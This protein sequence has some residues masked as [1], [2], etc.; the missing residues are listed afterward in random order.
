[1]KRP[2]QKLTLFIILLAAFSSCQQK[3]DSVRAQV[4]PFATVGAGIAGLG[5]VSAT[6]AQ[7]Q[8]SMGAIYDSANAATFQNR[9][10]SL[11]TATMYPEDVGTVGASI[12]D[13]T[14]VRFAGT[15]YLDSSGNVISSSSNLTISVYDSVWYNNSLANS[16]EQPIPLEFN[17][18]SGASLTGQ[19]NVTSGQGYLLVKDNYGE[20]R[21]DGTITSQ[22]FSGTVTFKNYTNVTGQNAASGSLGQFMINSCGIVRK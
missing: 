9:V 3:K 18:S 1:M 17:P 4:N 13:T 2:I 7:G 19:F 8:S 10:K 20:I 22:Y 15:M 6:C 16:S 12:N 14:G 11:L 21:F 5:S